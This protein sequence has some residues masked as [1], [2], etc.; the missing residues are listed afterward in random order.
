MQYFGKI[1]ISAQAHYR[2]GDITN[3][4]LEVIIKYVLLE[5][6]A[7]HE[8]KIKNRI[9]HFGCA[10]VCQHFGGTELVGHAQTTEGGPD[11]SVGFPL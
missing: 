5:R 7:K 3:Q 6:I 8:K 10:F 9:H 2:K 11:A 4:K 1:N